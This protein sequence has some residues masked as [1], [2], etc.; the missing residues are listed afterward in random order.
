MRSSWDRVR[1]GAIVAAVLSFALVAGSARGAEPAKPAEAAKPAAAAAAA[2][3]PE[4]APLRERVSAYWKARVARDKSVVDYYVPLEK[5]AEGTQIGEGG[6][7]RFD[8]FEITEVALTGDTASVTMSI[9]SHIDGN[10]PFPI[11]E[12]VGR[13][14]LRER[15]SRI[16]GVWYKQPSVPAMRAAS[17]D[18]QRAFD[19]RREAA[20]AAEAQKS[21]AGDAGAPQQSSGSGPLPTPGPGP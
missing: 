12:R 8:S 9:T 6:A 16:D 21:K 14:T 13:R 10:T 5:R 18:L 1:G 3:K 4:E 7:V 15:W 2:V 20:Q 19:R 17:E 11:P